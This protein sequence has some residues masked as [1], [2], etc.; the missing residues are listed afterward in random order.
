MLAL[1]TLATVAISSAS[2][3]QLCKKPTPPTPVISKVTAEPFQLKQVNT[4]KISDTESTSLYRAD[5]VL[6]VTPPTAGASAVQVPVKVEL[7]TQTILNANGDGMT[8]GVISLFA[9]ST[10]QRITGSLVAINENF[11][12]LTGT[13]DG[14]MGGRSAAR[15]RAV[16]TGVFVQDADGNYTLVDVQTHG[17]QLTYVQTASTTAPRK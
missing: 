11:G 17:V 16:F 1:V 13:I 15:L 12:E 4:R 3:G 10:K 8:N 7:R 14:A 9:P 2:A 6:T 5:A